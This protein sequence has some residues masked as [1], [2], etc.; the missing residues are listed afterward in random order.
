MPE[1]NPR[2]AVQ[3]VLVTAEQMQQIEDRLFQAGMPVAALM[4]KVSER[5]TRWFVDC[6][7]PPKSHIGVLAGPGHNGGD[8][9]VVARELHH[10]GYRV[11]VYQPFFKL[12][13]LTEQHAKYAKGL[14]IPFVQSVADLA[15]CEAIIDG[16][17][18]FG[19]TRPMTGELDRKSVV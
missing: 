15:D 18:G 6:Y 1:Q 2:P 3:S 10:A 7:G 19:L 8:A 17:F 9:L 11:S 14:G 12:K 5:L 4:E 13:K 16:W